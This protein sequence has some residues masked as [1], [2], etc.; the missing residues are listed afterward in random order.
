MIYRLLN[1]LVGLGVLIAVLG[2]ALDYIP[3]TSPGLNLPQFMLIC[4]GL[5]LSLTGMVLRGVGGSRARQF[6]VRAMKRRPIHCLLIVCF[7]LVALELALT[8]G[9]LAAYFPNEIPEKFLDP[10]PWWTCDGAGCHYVYDE[11]MAACER[12]EV[13]GRRCIVN[14]Q[15]FHDTQE[16]TPSPD[17][18]GRLRILILGDSFAYG[19]SAGIGMS[20][21]EVIERAFPR[22][23][24]WNTAMPGTGTNQAVMSYQVYA[25][26]LRPQ[27]TILGFFMNDF[28]D[29]MMPVD[30]YYYGVR[31]NLPP[32]AIRQYQVDL[33]GNVITLNRQSDLYY[34]Y[35]G[36]DPPASEAHRLLG[37]T[38][39][40]SLLIRSYNATRQ[41]LSQAEG[42]RLR[43]QA[44]A[45]RF[46]LQALRDAAFDT[47]L[48]LLLIPRREDLDRPG[49]RYQ[50]AL[51]LADELDIN[52]LTVRHLLSES[53]YARRPDVHWSAAGHQKAGVLLISCLEAF[54]A[55]RQARFCL[56]QNSD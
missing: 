38:R 9:G 22:A 33:R 35:K 11:V 8:I 55:D 15:G 42:K 5:G 17:L 37:T 4:S 45:T 50:L 19:N 53:D 23:I 6:A 49:E 47:E 21:V 30:S 56:S 24:I 52:Y 29:N 2:L 46:H 44:D 14:R 25:P 26:L 3:G 31:D 13:K 10:A 48:L 7:T 16:F 51:R 43:Q 28:D 20:F 40:G 39:L 36:V 12:G 54:K 41:M 27:I 18:D 1:T 32:L 34:R